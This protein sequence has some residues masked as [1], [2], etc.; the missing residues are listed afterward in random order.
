MDIFAVAVSP[1]TTL[2][3]CDETENGAAGFLNRMKLISMTKYAI[4][5]ELAY[6][7]AWFVK[8]MEISKDKTR[9][10]PSITAVDVGLR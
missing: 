3:R 10:L 6:I 4:I 9:A 5:R 8:A 2:T 1:A 7:S